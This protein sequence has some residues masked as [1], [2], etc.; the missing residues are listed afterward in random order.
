MAEKNIL[1]VDYEAGS[2]EKISKLLKA[3]KFHVVKASD[4][5]TGYDK[6]RAEK[7]DLV[8][9]EAMLPK[10]HGFDLIKR[11]VQESGGKVPVVVVTGLYKGPQYRQEVLSSLG[12][13]AFFEKPLDAEAFVGAV[14]RL[15]RDEEDFDDALPDSNAVIE[16]L[17]RLGRAGASPRG[18]G[19]SPH[20]GK[21]P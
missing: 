5:Q 13:A 8:V 9:L 4:G 10:M 18:E 11:I 17:C 1:V 14:K 12:A 7:P 6:F 21:R 19:K 16:S 15:L 2:L 3:N 20:K